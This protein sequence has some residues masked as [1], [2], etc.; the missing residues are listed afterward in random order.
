MLLTSCGPGRSRVYLGG[1][2]PSW[3]L[4]TV[5]VIRDVVVSAF[6]CSRAADFVLPE[7]RLATE[8]V[9][10]AELLHGGRCRSPARWRHDPPA[11]F[12]SKALK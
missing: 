1:R 2:H 8:D 7:P 9:L 11:L 10:Q 12:S 4:A 3:D 5:P 6:D